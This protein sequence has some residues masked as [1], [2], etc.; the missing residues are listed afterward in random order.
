M[1]V[2]KDLI[3]NGR[4]FLVIWV[5]L[6]AVFIPLGSIL[7]FMINLGIH[8]VI[9]YTVSQEG[10]HWLQTL[11]YSI[12][13]LLLGSLVGMTQWIILKR[14]VAIGSLWIITCI[15]GLI[16]GEIL[17]GIVLWKM[18]LN[19]SDL[20]W[21]QGGSLIA[22]ALIFLVS[23]LFVGLLQFPLLR[24]HFH[25]AW[26]WILAC[27]IG[28]GLVPLALVMFGGIVLGFITGTTLIWLL[29]PNKN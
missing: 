24:R 16:L 10:P 1:T 25:H 12:W 3:E 13:V 21:A 22:E 20:G 8:G 14:H 9:G 18:G 26:C 28:W 4:R 19:R 23:G 17:A 7:G 2:K 29:K 15:G 6:C 5:L 11:E 27:C